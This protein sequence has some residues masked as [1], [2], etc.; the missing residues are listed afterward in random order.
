MLLEHSCPIPSQ[1]NLSLNVHVIWQHMEHPPL[2]VLSIRATLYSLKKKRGFGCTGLHTWA[3]SSCG[4][5][6]GRDYSLAALAFS[7][8]S[9]RVSW[10][11]VAARHSAVPGTGSISN[12]W[13]P[14][15]LPHKFFN[16]VAPRLLPF[17]LT[18]SRL[19]LSYLGL[20]TSTFMS[21]AHYLNTQTVTAQLH[22][23]QQSVNPPFS[24]P[25]DR[26]TYPAL[27]PRCIM[28]YFHVSATPL[29]LS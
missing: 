12:H 3:F 22:T 20:F 26:L 28:H 29:S 15:S 21:P 8:Q 17:S 13:P 14:G 18:L 19:H 7:L 11:P 1:E 23:Y 4:E 6:G 16:T 25:H 9:P 10:P 2:I 24:V 27:I 5:R